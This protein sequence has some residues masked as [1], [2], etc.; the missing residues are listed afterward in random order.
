MKSEDLT[1]NFHLFEQNTSGISLPEK[2]TFPFYYDP[3]PLSVLASNQLKEQLEKIQLQH[4]FGLSHLENHSDE[5]LVIGKMFGVLV[6]KNEK[7]QLVFLQA[8]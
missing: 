1:A 3:H 7:N 6:V 4:N 8:F 2:F 5:E